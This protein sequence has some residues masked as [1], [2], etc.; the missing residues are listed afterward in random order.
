[1]ITGGTWQHLRSSGTWKVDR[2]NGKEVKLLAVSRYAT[3]SLAGSEE[4]I[5]WPHYVHKCMYEH[6][7][8]GLVPPLTGINWK[9]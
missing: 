7:S 4:K 2:N 8:L 9:L 3:S 5:Q 1:M 6:E